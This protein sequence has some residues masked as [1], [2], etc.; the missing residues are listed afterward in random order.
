MGKLT[1]KISK[2]GIEAAQSHAQAVERHGREI[3]AIGVRL[4]AM[5][6]L[7]HFTEASIQTA[8]E[9][10]EEVGQTVQVRGR[11]SLEYAKALQRSDGQSLAD[12]QASIQAHVEAAQLHVQATK[13]ILEL[14]KTTLENQQRL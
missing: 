13:V 7:P 12:Y 6:N 2:Q 3:E 10:I 8:G 1:H 11:S 9:W 5:A 14:A 4:K